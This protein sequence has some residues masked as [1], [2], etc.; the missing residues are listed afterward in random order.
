LES[1]GETGGGSRLVKQHHLWYLATGALSYLAV[2]TLEMLSVG[3]EGQLLRTEI[4]SLH[5]FSHIFFGIGL[6]SLILFLRPRSTARIVI[7]A[8]L[9]A[10]IAWELHEG[11]WLRGE[12]IDSVEDVVLAILSAS[13]FLCFTRMNGREP[14]S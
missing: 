7:L 13:T 5:G 14:D 12:P 6:A 9:V 2:S 3:F 8:V 1:I 4:Y 10:G 11:Y